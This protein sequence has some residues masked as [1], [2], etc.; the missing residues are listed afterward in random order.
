MFEVKWFETLKFENLNEKL[1]FFTFKNFDLC[2]KNNF[3]TLISKIVIFP[4]IKLKK[5]AIKI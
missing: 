3:R 5:L 4:P 1:S 2:T